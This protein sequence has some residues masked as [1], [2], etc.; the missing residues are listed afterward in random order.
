MM[1]KSLPPLI[2]T[3]LGLAAAG[4]QDSGAPAATN[5]SAV[6]LSSAFTTLPVGFSEV[7]STF[8]DSTGTQWG[9]GA[10]G[11]GHQGGGGDMMCGGLGGFVGFGL[12]FGGGHGLLAGE[13]SGNCAFDAS[14]GR[15]ACDPVTR[16]GLTVTRSAQYAD[17]NGAA[18]QTFDS[19][20]TNTVN[21]QVTVSGTRIRR[22]GDTAQVQ[23]AS[24]R[25]VTGLVSASTGP[26][27]NG[28]SAGTET[29]TGSDSVGTFNAV[30]TIGDTI[31][32]V[33][34]PASSASSATSYPTAGTI[35]RSMLVTVM[36]VGQSPTTSSRREV[37]TFNGSS[38]ATV[39]VTKDGTT[40]NCTLPLPRGRLTCS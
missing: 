34:L 23:H 39:V 28:T 40:Q 5:S 30:R 38:T 32:N 22:D 6:D 36:Y 11:Q 16:D 21:L 18:Q 33:V 8:G 2:V 35:I 37:V 19:L 13:L 15:V 24:D 29:T 17:A 1:R 10:G 31:Q 4:C 26:T 25:T 9:P 7:Q 20:T 3:V 14:S 12:G 27:I